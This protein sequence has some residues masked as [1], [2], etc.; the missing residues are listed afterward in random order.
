MLTV[1]DSYARP[2]CSPENG[3]SS[4]VCLALWKVNAETDQLRNRGPG[5]ISWYST[6]APP[7]SRAPSLLKP[8]S[9]AAK[10][11]VISAIHTPHVQCSALW[12]LNSSRQFAPVI[13]VRV[14]S[15]SSF[16]A[17][18]RWK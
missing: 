5:V 1:P 17:S 8:M 2:H 16:S 6:R 4:R 15:T 13:R 14:E 18:G 7:S 12:R 10:S 3:A 9:L 11:G